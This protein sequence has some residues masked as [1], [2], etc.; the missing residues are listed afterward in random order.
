[1]TIVSR[2]LRRALT[3]SVGAWNARLDRELTTSLACFPRDWI[4][5]D[6][7]VNGYYE[8]DLLELLARR[9]FPSLSRPG[10]VAL[11]VGANIGNHSVFFS[12]HF[13]RVIAFEPNPIA[14]HLLRAN[15]LFND[16][17]GVDILEYGLGAREAELFL[18]VPQGNLGAARLRA[19]RPVGNRTVKCMVKKGDDVI[20]ALLPEGASLAFV[21]LD[22]EGFE[23]DVIN[24]LQ[25]TLQI[26]RP[27]VAFESHR[28]GGSQGGRAVAERLQA[29][30]ITHLYAP[31]DPVQRQ[32]RLHAWVTRV[33]GRALELL[34]IQTLE[35]GYHRLVLASP[36]SL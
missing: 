28:T 4:G 18:H 1:L 19:E 30:G 33:R 16:C 12:R 36:R 23:L 2:I 27:V 5:R 26:H 22:V 3:S 24:G 25:Q 11:D 10:A 8:R 9:V 17:N 21:K 15:V 32:G 20:P 34:P 7:V 29:L 31:F 6:I 35:D 14:V 13:E